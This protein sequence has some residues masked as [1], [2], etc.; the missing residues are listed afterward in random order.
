MSVDTHFYPLGSCTMKY[1]PKRHERLA[2][3]P[4]LVDLH[5]YLPDSSCQGMLEMLY[6]LQ[7]DAGGDRRTSRGFAAARRRERKGSWRLC[8][9][10]RRGFATAAKPHQGPV[11]LQRPRHQSGQRGLGGV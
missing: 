11:P 10:R 1:N 2:G 5:P 8:S 4:G 3:L 7:A 6:E 9:R